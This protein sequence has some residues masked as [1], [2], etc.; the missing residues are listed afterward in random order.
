[1]RGRVRLETRFRSRA[2]I[3]RDVVAGCVRQQQRTAVPTT[4]KS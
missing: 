4:S 2:G 1:V 3:T